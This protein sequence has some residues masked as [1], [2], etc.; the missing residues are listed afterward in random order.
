M[1][2]NDT[3]RESIES[4]DALAFNRAFETMEPI[5]F[6]QMA[7]DFDDDTLKRVLSL[8]SD[9]NR[10]KVF[11]E[12]E[13][14]FRLR[15][16]KLT[17][18]KS[19]LNTFEHMQKDDIVDLLGDFPTGRRKEVLDLMKTDDRQIITKLLNYPEDSAGGIM[20]TAYLSLNE[21]LTIS[22]GL[23]KIREIAPRTEVIETIY[24]TDAQHRLTGSL[25]LRELLSTAKTETIRSIM[26]P[27]V[28]YVTPE[29][30]QEEVAK[31]V[32]RYDLNAIPVVNAKKQLLGIITV[33]DVI[34]VIIEE[35][36]EDM[37]QMAGVSSEERLN[38]SLGQSI[39]FRLP[40]LLVNLATAFLASFTVKMFESTINKVV[41]L[42]A[43]MTI[44]SGMGGNAG[45][46]T[47]SVLVRE[48]SH[49]KITTAEAVKG[50]F[51]EILLGIIDGAVNGVVTGVA[52]YF[53]YGNFYLGVIVLVA[54]IG[55]MIVAGVFGFLVPLVLD[56][57]HADP[58]VASSIFV[59]TATD[60]LGFFIFLGLATIFMPLLL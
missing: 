1:E 58:A 6:A 4:G 47:M 7:E 23:Q 26:D 60:V 10:A 15:M 8:L 40:W 49:N 59:T 18:N 31:K 12:A 11:E 9:E 38:T 36:D 5:D 22:Q 2:M 39:R 25:D 35:H 54:M 33:D 34:D 55:N 37:L 44:V 41:A 56:K 16:A 21:N 3:I 24:V 27:G 48:L 43:I 13:D 32:S 51:K 19:L 17:D 30:D 29:V 52:V 57:I 20:T 28:I 53:I 50:F 45:T 14:D 42:S 46:Q